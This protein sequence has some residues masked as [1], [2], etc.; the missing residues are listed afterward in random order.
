MNQL[1]S[2][3]PTNHAHG[4]SLH[5]IVDATGNNSL[6]AFLIL[7]TDLIGGCLAWDSRSRLHLTFRSFFFSLFLFLFLIVSVLII[8]CILLIIQMETQTNK[9][10]IKKKTR[11]GTHMIIV[12]AFLKS[13]IQCRAEIEISLLS[14]VSE[15]NA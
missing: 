12:M 6:Y 2:L 4:V 9:V 10:Y 13:S 8:H 14:R 7:F 15:A 11:S 1:M 3:T 5:V